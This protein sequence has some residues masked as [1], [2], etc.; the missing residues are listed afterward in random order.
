MCSIYRYIDMDAMSNWLVCRIIIDIDVNFYFL[1][2]FGDESFLSQRWLFRI[3]NVPWVATTGFPLLITDP[4][5]KVY[6]LCEGKRIKK[7]KTTMKK[8]TLSPVYNEALVFDVPAENVEDV[9]LIVKVIDYDR[10]GIRFRQIRRH[11]HTFRD[12]FCTDANTPLGLQT[13]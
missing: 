6:L 3:C 13:G 8:S 12:V 10:Y 7:K 5:V 2:I 4:Y 1:P 9:S 11:L